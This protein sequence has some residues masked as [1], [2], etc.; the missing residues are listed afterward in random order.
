ME[1]QSK[2]EK[3]VTPN[4]SVSVKAFKTLP[5]SIDIL[6]GKDIAEMKIEE[7]WN[8]TNLKVIGVPP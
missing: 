8:G 3:I 6:L 2:S 4:I 7:R 5:M 1:D